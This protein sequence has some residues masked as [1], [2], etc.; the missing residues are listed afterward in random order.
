MLSRLRRTAALSALMLAGVAA[1]AHAA[2][3]PKVSE[4]K[5]PEAAPR[6]AQIEPLVAPVKRAAPKVSG[7][8][9]K[10]A[11]KTTKTAKK[12][13]GSAD[14]AKV[15]KSDAPAKSSRPANAVTSKAHNDDCAKGFKLSDT[16]NK[17]VRVAA[18]SGQAK[19]AT[20]KLP[21]KKSN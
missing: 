11:A 9:E 19:N 4:Q 1:L 7:T 10:P 18:S 13:G 6:A 2:D 16:G 5:V 3:A 12:T 15:K 21:R 14:K 17:C 8:K 20:A